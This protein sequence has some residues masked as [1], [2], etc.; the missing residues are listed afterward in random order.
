MN[1]NHLITAG[2]TPGPTFQSMLL[3]AG[4]LE[5]AGIPETQIFEMLREEFPPPPPKIR[6]RETAL[7]CREA[8]VATTAEETVN[9]VNVRARMEELLKC[10]VVLAGAIMPDACPAGSA[11]ATIP[12]GGAIVTRNAI[13][14]SAHSADICCSMYA[15]FY[16][17]DT[18]VAQELDRLLTATRFGPG[19]HHKENWLHHT[20]NDEP[21]W[22]NPFLQGLQDYARKHMGDQGDGNH[23][24]YIGETRFSTTMLNLL[25]KTGHIGLAKQFKANH[26]YRVL[27]THHGS[28]GLGAQLYKRGQA[29]ALRQTEKIAEDVPPA[30][31]WIDA[32]SKE[33]QDYW[34]ALQYIGRWTKTNHTVI[35]QR[36]LEKID[37]EPT[38][39]FGNE[40]NYV[41]QRGCEFY[42]G[43]GATPAWLDKEG[44]PQ[45]GLIPMNMASQ[46]LMVLGTNNTDFLGFAP[47]G[48]GRNLSRTALKNKIGGAE[49]EAQ[50][51][52]DSTKGIDVR[53][54]SGHADISESPVAY[55]D[56][57]TVKT[58]IQKFDLAE[59]IC[60][61]QPLGCIMAGQ[62]PEAPWETTRR[63]KKENSL[64]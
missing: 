21:V 62:F 29:T 44:R 43:K 41:W 47:H 38:A 8:I 37:T 12:V 30:A 52:A 15:S 2:F 1:G 55:K 27:V 36:F 39:A 60:E 49:A 13:I 64:A 32:E 51:L 46:I 33:G 22:D 63:L 45:I 4:E 10:P 3:R 42:H 11:P 19:G 35:H 24:A 28:R 50:V 61:I 20:V 34:A 6:M 16:E 17:S 26:T 7:P 48:A 14:P 18:P 58:Q 59:V 31:A 40:H 53:W 54:Y 23:F 9:L 57:E 25:E 5:A 56:A